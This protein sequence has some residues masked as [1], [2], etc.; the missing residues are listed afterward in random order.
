MR[1]KQ[2]PE[3]F[4]VKEIPA[5]KPIG[6]GDYIWCTL[7]KI[8][9]DLLK[10][11]KVF[12]NRLQISRS[13]IGYAGTKD[14]VAVTYQTISFWNVSIQNLKR[15]QINGAELFDFEYNQR[16]IKLGELKGNWFSITV[17]DL[18][19]KYTD[20]FLEKR[21]SIINKNGVVNFFGSQRFGSRNITHLVGKEIIKNNIPESIF[22]YLTKTNKNEDVETRKAREFLAETENFNKAVTL[23][24]KGSK[25]DLAIINHIIQYPEDYIGA[26]RCLPKTLQLMF[27]HAYQS[28]LWNLV[29]KE[30]S[31]KHPGKNMQIPVIGYNTKLGSTEIDRLC[32]KVL[33][34]EKIKTDDFKIRSIPELTCLGS[35]RDIL[36]YPKKT[37]YKFGKDEIN[38]GKDKVVVEFEL[39]KGSYGTQVIKEIFN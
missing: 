2:I 21:V 38:R 13:R 11:L 18:E 17:R 29:A 5:A 15:L 36:A 26:I 10:L 7:R 14:K 25:W 16:P 20:K 9:W 39:P 1:I 4:V 27:I 28:Y 23:F 31:R 30:I 24:P 37:D 6:Q 33:N 22:L 19:K 8:N 35:K 34:R 12:A 3:D 32:K